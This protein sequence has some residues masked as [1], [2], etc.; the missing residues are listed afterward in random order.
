MVVSGE[1]ANIIILYDTFLDPWQ[2]PMLCNSKSNGGSMTT[3]VVWWVCCAR[4]RKPANLWSIILVL[5]LPLLLL[6]GYDPQLNIILRQSASSFVS[7]LSSWRLS[8]RGH[9]VS[10]PWSTYHCRGLHNWPNS[11]Y[12]RNK[13]HSLLSLPPYHPPL[14][15][16]AS[17]LTTTKSAQQFWPKAF[18]S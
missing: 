1:Y 9:K 4:E 14:F 18:P 6:H 3:C 7:L 17:E 10:K 13:F 5:T 15:L 12:T 2:S 8:D 11:C 16:K